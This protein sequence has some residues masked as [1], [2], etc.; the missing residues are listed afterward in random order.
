MTE[1]DLNIFFSKTYQ[2][3]QAISNLAQ[4]LGDNDVLQL[5]YLK[6]GVGSLSAILRTFL[7]IFF[8]ATGTIISRN[9]Q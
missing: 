2:P 9:V 5:N 6:R 1:E 7:T 3:R 4:M 8:Q